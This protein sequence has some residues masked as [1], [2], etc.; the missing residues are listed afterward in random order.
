MPVCHGDPAAHN[1]ILRPDGRVQMIDLNSLRV[2]LPCVDLWKLT[3]R[4][5]FWR[6]WSPE[7]VVEVLT[8]YNR[9]HAVADE[10]TVLLGLL[11]FPEKQ[12]RLVYNAGRHI[13]RSSA[14]GEGLLAPEG[15]ID[16]MAMAGALLKAKEQCLAVVERVL[17]GR[18]RGYS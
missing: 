5:A 16:E 12:W 17:L 9:A 1:L 14:D 11:W 8:A 15:V 2:D 10:A 7:P 13:E 18:A 4:M 3:H 6:G